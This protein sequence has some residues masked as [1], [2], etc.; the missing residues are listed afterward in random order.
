MKIA[1]RPHVHLTPLKAGRSGVKIIR[2]NYLSALH[3]LGYDPTSSSRGF[4]FEGSRR[5][6]S[7]QILRVATCGEVAEWPK[8]PVC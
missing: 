3:A 2:E 7:I 6:N 5:G 1:A 4:V 8:A